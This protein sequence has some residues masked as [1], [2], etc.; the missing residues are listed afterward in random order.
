MFFRD[1]LL[2]DIKKKK[3]SNI[4]CIYPLLT[5]INIDYIFSCIIILQSMKNKLYMIYK[6][7]N[8]CSYISDSIHFY[9][10]SFFYI[11]IYKLKNEIN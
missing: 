6:Q 8:R 4:N 11:Y 1:N 9:K 3:T 5:I 2:N 7:I 10:I